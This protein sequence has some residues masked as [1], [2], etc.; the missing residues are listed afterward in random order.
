MNSRLYFIPENKFN[1]NILPIIIKYINNY[2]YL[3]L[4][5]KIKTPSQTFYM[6]EIK[7]Q[8]DENFYQ[9]IKNEAKKQ[10]ITIDA[11]VKKTLVNAINSNNK[12]DNFDFQKV[13]GR[14]ANKVKKLD[15]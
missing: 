14:L 6:S 5:Y 4:Y 12:E 13:L 7:I 3:S 11:F 10:G 2:I 8:T 9:A 1:K 15:N